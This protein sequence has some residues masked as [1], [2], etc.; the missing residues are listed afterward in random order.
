MVLR[1]SLTWG[2]LCS[3]LTSLGCTAEVSGPNASGGA[4]SSTTNGGAGGS[5]TTGGAGG[6]M[7]QAACDATLGLA[8]PRLW[9]LNDR[10]YDNVVHD[11]FGAAIVVP[12]DVSAAVVAGAED[13]TGATSLKID[14]VT[15]VQ[16][17]QRSAQATASSAVANL[18]ALLPCA[19]PDAACVETF[20]RSKVSRA[21]RRP[22]TDEQVQDMLAI[23]QLGAAETPAAGVQALLQ[24]VLQAPAFLWR[25]ELAGIDPAATP[26]KPEPLGPFELA[27]A[28]SFLFV[29]STP[30]DALW[31]KAADG[32]IT[33]TPVLAAEVDRLLALPAVKAN[34]AAKVGSWLS[35]R[36][37]EVTVKDPKVFPE[38]TPSVMSGLTQSVQLFLKDVVERG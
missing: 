31:A 38:F 24:Y 18:G 25:T 12:P 11:V 30:D 29:D 5:A 13:A 37:T 26:T 22:V 34:I 19:T 6:G 23:Y 33:Q 3:L 15:T 7:P 32:S 1:R 20:I 16:N 28:L 17:Y 4:S 27:A 10:Q 21:F 14:D 9:R 36:K 35:V 2:A 8:P